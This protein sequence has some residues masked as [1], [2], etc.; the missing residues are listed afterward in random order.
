MPQ[1]RGITL[2]T[3]N[4]LIMAT[5]VVYLVAMVIIGVICS[6]KNKSTDD[7]YLGGR[8]LGPLVTAMSAEASDMSSYLLMG[9]PGLALLS[10]LADVG[11]TVIGLA[12]GTYLN[13]LIVAKRIRRYSQHIGAVTVPDFFSR[14]YHDDKNLLSLIAALVIIVFFIP[15]TAS[16]FNACGTLFSSLFGVDYFTAMVV[17]AVV[18]V[19]YTALG[20]FLAASTTDLIQSIIMTIA[21]IIVVFFGIHMAGGWD[22][23]VSNAQTLPGYLSFTQ[24]HDAASGAANAYTPVTIL[25][26]LAWGLGYFG[27]PHILLRFMAIEDVKKL[28]TSRRIA[29]TWVVISM[30]IAV[31]IGV[32]GNGMI[33]AGALESIPAADSQ[34]IIIKISTL[35]SSYGVLPA[36]V[37]GLI[38]SGILAATMSTADSQL[39]AAASSVTQDLLQGTFKLKLSNKAA[40]VIARLTVIVIAI[41]GVIWARNEGSVFT[42]VS[43]AWAGF[44]A[45]FGPVVLLALFW[46]RSN[47]YGALAGMIAGGVMVFVWKYCIAP[48]GGILNIY[49][50]LPAFV[51]AIIVNVVVSLATKAP[52]AEV[53]KE[54]DEVAAMKD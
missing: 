42:I 22:A 32:V 46:K 23:V 33:H 29:S 37:A 28:K 11:W 10:G 1:G 2:N 49:E 21:L 50:L 48:I 51:I 12:V 19:L 4:I 44:G 3:Q 17:S 47:K 26:T 14:R 8:K 34:R 5:I 6:K 25:S 9:L 24:T 13:W 30:A 20:G 45:A 7:F 41:I 54:Y 53:V 52:E 43:F 38:L 18:I 40:M 35:L 15:H 31:L 39:L 16:G 36:I 27:M